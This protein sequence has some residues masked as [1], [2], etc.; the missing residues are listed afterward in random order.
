[1]SAAVMLFRYPRPEW[2]TKP[3]D[4]NPK[5]S[6]SQ[7]SMRAAEVARLSGIGP[8]AAA[9]W[10]PSSSVHP[11]D[12]L[13]LYP[14]LAVLASIGFFVLGSSYWGYCYVFGFAFLILSLAMSLALSWSPLL[15]GICLGSCFAL[16]GRRLRGL[17]RNQD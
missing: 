15:Y 14:Q 3:G 1:M 13:I 11:F 17:A 8:R 9:N 5:P 4:R 7:S 10:L 12:P 6:R 16:L 2:S